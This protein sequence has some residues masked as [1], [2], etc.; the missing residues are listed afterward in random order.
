[1]QHLTSPDSASENFLRVTLASALLALLGACGETAA[2]P[3]QP[4]AAPPVRISPTNGDLNGKTEPE[5]FRRLGQPV[6]EN[7]EGGAKRL[8]FSRNGCVIDAY[9]FPLRLNGQLVVTHIDSRRAT[10][11]DLALATCLKLYMDNR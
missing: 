6:Q 4:I 2:P 11:E 1:M 8:Q 3:P 10:G 5:L 7:I 9:L